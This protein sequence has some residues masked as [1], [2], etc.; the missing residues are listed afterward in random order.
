M[1]RP[2]WRAWSY[3]DWNSNLVEHCFGS[4]EAGA[5]E[6]VERIVATPQELAAV[7]GDPEA[8]PDEVAA[9]FVTAMKRE[10]PLHGI[11]FYAFCSDT[12]AR[13][14]TLQSARVP[15][16]F[17]MLWLTC[18]VANG[19]PDGGADE[20]HRRI[21]GLFGRNMNL[22]CLPDL[23]SQL[24]EWTSIRAS[25][26]AGPRFR[27]LVLPPPDRYRTVIGSS[28]FLAF[29]HA[30]DRAKLCQLLE[31][32]DLVGEEPALHRTVA[33]LEVAK[34]IFSANFVKDLDDF[35]RDFYSKDRDVRDSAFWRAIR[36]EAL[37]ATRD[38]GDSGVHRTDTRLMAYYDADDDLLVP[39]VACSGS[40]RLP[41]PYVKGDLNFDVDGLD[42]CVFSPVDGELS[43]QAAARAAF[44][45]RLPVASAALHFRRGVMIFKAV[46]RGEYELVGG[47]A[48]DNADLAL[49]RDDLVS[50]F[51]AHY[52]GVTDPA[53]IDGLDG[54]R[55]VRDCRVSIRRDAP[56]G[57]ERV[58]HL[59]ATMAPPVVRIV[60]GIRGDDGFVALRGQLPVVRFAGAIRV[61]VES[62]D[63]RTFLAVRSSRMPD[64]WLL[65]DDIVTGP[66]GRYLVRV[67]WP[68]PDGIQHVTA[69]EFRLGAKQTDHRY[70]PLPAG[71][72]VTEG[73]GL[74][75]A[76]F[77]RGEEVSSQI[78][79][80]LLKEDEDGSA[81]PDLI[82]TLSDVLYLGASPG[83]VSRTRRPAQDWL[84][85]G[86][87]HNPRLL[88][89]VGNPDMPEMRSGRKSTHDGSRSVW[90]NTM[91]KS[92]TVKV[93]TAA[94]KTEVVADHPKVAKALSIFKNRSLDREDRPDESL[95]AL[96]P[97]P[98]M[99]WSGVDSA[100]GVKELVDAVAALAC[101]RSGIRLNSLVE[102]F[103][104]ATG[105]N[106]FDH[107]ATLY[108]LLRAWVEA[109]L[110]DVF[111]ARGQPVSNVL[112]RRPG[113]VAY[114]IGDGFRATL[115]GLLPSSGAFALEEAAARRGGTVVQS[116]FGANPW[117]PEA[118]RLD[119]TDLSVLR[120][121]TRELE[122]QPVRWFDPP[123]PGGVS[124]GQGPAT[125]GSAPAYLTE[126]VWDWRASRFVH[127]PSTF[128][129]I[130][131]QVELRRHLRCCPVYVVT[132]DG[133]EVAW[134]EVRNSALIWAYRLKYDDLPFSDE[135]G[136]PV[137]RTWAGGLYL[138]LRYGRL[139]AVVGAGLS[140]PAV[141]S[142]G[143]V[144][145]YTY[146]LYGTFREPLSAFLKAS[147][148]T[149]RFVH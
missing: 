44:E 24:Q 12:A 7:T 112:A 134:S 113:F 111:H 128:A 136:G 69:G 114:R 21:A 116:V 86:P 17:A 106:R 122:L 139:C 135:A 37:D 87:H 63:N 75:A 38:G 1:N 121:I 33:V 132:D 147:T 137:T 83:D 48:A 28:W 45:G 131:V 39:Y 91:H 56:E 140:G 36:R 73:V 105:W 126:K 60:G 138:P 82:A 9:R 119:V 89:F 125:C 58:G 16:F 55:Q 35:V 57:L 30:Q 67:H 54:W 74:A 41:E 64:D 148:E 31:E 109:G 70:K 4:D 120:E 62:P 101:R 71:V 103:A 94:G 32:H 88:L 146:P 115:L 92:R 43:M 110:L 93:R 72:H 47:Q 149:A 108:E 34:P 77:E 65:P 22:D 2:D 142:S 68:T 95:A 133:C 124:P 99:P 143:Q 20:Y 84:L 52:G 76:A 53:A 117:Q 129:R 81:R 51:A 27:R 10:L 127:A 49:V 144:T 25:T 26:S 23:W 13:G 98:V 102:V 118:L 6:P 14:W 96:T 5:V 61:E 66:P 90:L 42:C 29:P 85:L 59:Q 145:S 79:G 3:N 19:Y 50:R 97:V 141:D 100:V 107:A 11:S 104:D 40:A 130:G 8:A 15:H 78:A 123:G 80:A 18:L 46:F